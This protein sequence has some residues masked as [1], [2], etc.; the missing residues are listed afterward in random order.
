MKS[1]QSRLRYMDVYKGVLMLLVI[2]GHIVYYTRLYAGLGS[3]IVFDWFQDV[4]NHWIAPFYMAAF[5]VATGFCSSFKKPVKEQLLSDFKTLIVPAWVMTII[6]G[7]V[8]LSG[9]SDVVLL[10]KRLFLQGSGSYWFV[11]SMFVAKILY[12]F[13]LKID[14][15]VVRF[16]LLFV[17]SVIGTYLNS[18]LPD[19]FWYFYHAL[20][21]CVFFEVGR[22][23]RSLDLVKWYVALAS[24]LVYVLLVVVLLRLGQRVPA[25]C[26]VQTFKYK[27][28]PVYFLLATTGSVV[29]LYVCKCVGSCSLLEYVGQNSVVYYIT[30]FAFF[31]LFIPLASSFIAAYQG[32]IVWSLILF[33]AIFVGAI[34]WSTAISLLVNTKYLRWI[35]GKSSR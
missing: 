20:S 27:M 13:A 28:M 11:A 3:N 25:L 24:L 17:V 35:V 12:R 34:L 32:S 19:K 23:L 4:A 31:S 29:C 5:F 21:L 16:A 26:A 18:H 1:N 8:S 7:L 2:Y 33:F 30:H 10:A 14:R 15:S 22:Q 9:W 6:V